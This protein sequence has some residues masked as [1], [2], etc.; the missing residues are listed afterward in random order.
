MEFREDKSAATE[1]I[2]GYGGGGFRIGEERIRGHLLISPGGMHPWPAGSLESLSRKTVKPLF[3]KDFTP[4]FLLVGAGREAGDSVLL[5]RRLSETL[6]VT[7]EV[8]S[9]GAAVRTY[10]VLVLEG[11]QVAAALIAVE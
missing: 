6:G 10:N 7:V 11:R 1:L 4:E 2:T 3:T 9:T 8:M 5:A